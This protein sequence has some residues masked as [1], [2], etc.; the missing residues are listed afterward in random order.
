MTALSERPVVVWFRNDLRLADHPAL[1]AAAALG[2]P[3]LPVFVLDDESPGAWATGGAGRW[4]L[5]GSLEALAEDLA[6]LGAPLVLRR[7]P[8]D[9]VITALAIETAAAAVYWNRHVE[10]FAIAVEQ[11]LAAALSARGIAGRG[12]APSLLFEPGTVASRDGRPL[13]IFTPFWRSC[14]AA[15]EPSAP[16]PRPRSLCPPKATPPGD[17][18]AGW[19]LRPTSPDW[20]A[21]LRATWRP[22]EAAARARCAVFVDGALD[23]YHRHRDR[24][25]P[26][27]TSLLSPHLHCGEISSRQVWHAVRHA[28]AASS[29]LAAGADAYL[30]EIGWREFFAHTLAA[31]PGLAEAPLQERF[32]GFPWVRDER[33]LAAWQRGRTGYPFVDAGMRQLWTTGWMHNRVRMVVASFLVKHLL[34][35][36]QDGEAWFWDTLVDADL[37]SNAGGWQWVAGCGTDAAPYF[38]IFNPVLQ[39]EKFDADGAYVRRWVPELARLPARWIHRPWEA[40]AVELAAAE[41]HLGRTYPLPVIEH[42]RARARALAAFEAIKG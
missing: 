5:H 18:L 26:A 40:P 28:E 37:A 20:A 32:A 34:V 13:K 25:E 31:R 9:D 14:L 3:L 6:A 36:W 17:R 41:I 7:G 39:G 1:T 10:P 11:R 21:G 42:A 2:A 38:R 16:L 29:T 35:A 4:W 30:R 12:F 8:A 22:G 33:L 23:G 27:A 19:D 15:G 24:P